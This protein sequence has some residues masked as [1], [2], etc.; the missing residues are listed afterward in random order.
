MILS[1]YIE[2]VCFGNHQHSIHTQSNCNN[3]ILHNTQYS[4]IRSHIHIFVI[5][6]EKCWQIIENGQKNTQDNDDEK[7]RKCEKHLDLINQC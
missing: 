6:T 4:R 2:K 3:K 1:C 5:I 7:K